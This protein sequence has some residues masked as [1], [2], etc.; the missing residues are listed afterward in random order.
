MLEMDHRAAEPVRDGRT[1]RAAGDVL[2]PEHEVV[3]EQLRAAA[4]QVG[5]RRRAVR[6]LELIVLVDGDPGQLLAAPGDLVAAA[7]QL[8]LGLEQVEPRGQPLL[9]GAD[10][11]HDRVTPRLAR[12]DDAAWSG[13]G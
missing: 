11:V 1:R 7:R 8:L 12:R 6:R 13:S 5:E 9:A 2:G 4:E 10:R 3:D